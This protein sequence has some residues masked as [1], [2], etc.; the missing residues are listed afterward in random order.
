M[1]VCDYVAQFIA[2]R[3]VDTVFSI[4][5]G[6]CIF[7][8]DAFEREERIEMVVNHHEQGCALSAEGYARAKGDMGVCLVT[9]GPG[10]SN[11]W[12]GILCS[13]QD[14]VPVM[15]ISGNVNKSMTT[16][17][18]GLDLR[19]LGDQEFDTVKTVSNFTKYAV[20]VNDANTIKYHL[21]KAYYE[22]NNGRKGPVWI[23]IPL[24]IST[25]TVDINK[26][27]GFTPKDPLYDKVD[28]KSIINKLSNS[29]KP[30]IIVGNGVRL[31]N[32]VS[33][34]DGIL[35][36]YNIPVVTS[37][38]GNDSVSNEYKYFGGRFGT[39]GQISA[40]KLIQE[41]DFILSLGSRLYV[42]QIGYNFKSFAKNAY[43]IYVDI[44]KREL[45]KP[46]LFPD[47]KVNTDVNLF[48]NK[49]KPHLMQLN[50]DPWRDTCVKYV[51]KYPHVLERHKES[52]SPL[53]S[54]GVFDKLNEYINKYDTIVTSNG[55][56]NIVGMQ[57]L[58]LKKN[59]RMFTNKATAPMGYGL[60]AAIGS[61]Y[62]TKNKILLLDGDGSLHMNI[63]E[64]QVL[65]QNNLPIKIILLNNSGYLSIKI[66]QTNFCNGKLSLSDK[67]SGLT[68][69]DYS[70]IAYAYNLKYHSIKNKK[71]LKSVFGDVFT[72][73][74]YNGPELI[75][76]FV[77][78]H[79][80]HEPK[81]KAQLDENGKFTPGELDSINWILE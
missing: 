41:S 44:D 60:P 2:D 12:T 76:V 26:L 67:S 25:D 3:N 77:D 66:T 23:D 10:G 8:S 73:N 13:Y 36:D 42:R 35:E 79:E 74:T 11:A 51:D 50:I 14:S 15:V 48:L 37:L 33:L 27:K 49:L 70:K 20:Q 17:Y 24:D 30:L 57:V 38:N 65:V 5:G 31:S 78:P 59:Q 21:E 56:S 29:K 71:D 54:Y 58:K 32:S 47:M 22:A 40:N 43:K 64:L 63:H 7:L 39:A 9:S 1:K 19:Q 16:N 45:N 46:T 52:N 53:S 75:E 62:G 4:P 18:T 6:G 68:L 34:L 72:N 81:V 80:V 55:T 28:I 61:H 69:P